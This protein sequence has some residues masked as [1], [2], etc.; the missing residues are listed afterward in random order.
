MVPIQVISAT[1]I[2][3]HQLTQESGS[4]SSDDS[5]MISI[6]FRMCSTEISPT[7]PTINQLPQFTMYRD[8][9]V[10]LK[11]REDAKPVS[12]GQSTA[13]G[14]SSKDVSSQWER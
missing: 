3:G 7:L 9:D 8:I 1:P 2:S 13:P 11:P 6:V 5:T 12:Q 4:N 10:P 14:V